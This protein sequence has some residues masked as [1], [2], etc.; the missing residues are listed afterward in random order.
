V[1]TLDSATGPRSSRG[2]STTPTA[3][4]R[5]PRRTAPARARVPVSYP[6]RRPVTASGGE[7]A[8]RRYSRASTRR[9]RTSLPRLRAQE[10]R[11]T[12][13][14]DVAQAV[15]VVGFINGSYCP[16]GCTYVE[17]WRSAPRNAEFRYAHISAYISAS[18]MTTALLSSA[19]VTT[20]RI[21]PR[22]LA[23]IQLP[24]EALPERSCPLT[25]APPSLGLPRRD[26]PGRSWPPP[27]RTRP[28][29]RPGSAGLDRM[30]SCETLGG[31]C[32]S[33][34]RRL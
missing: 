2:R 18:T 11:A 10:R 31:A 17:P 22:P 30:R 9:V 4:R 15:L 24:G 23:L 5:M 3:E 1:Y 27:A 14:D 28:S 7:S 6:R 21:G 34:V 32:C 19:R 33:N 29:G 16:V 13:D 8:S 12:A 20:R 25:E 26:G